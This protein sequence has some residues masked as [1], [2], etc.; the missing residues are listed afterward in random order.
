MKNSKNTFF[1]N[2]IAKYINN[3]STKPEK[4]VVDDFFISLSENLLW[5]EQELGNKDFVKQR[6]K[7][8]IQQKVF[9]SKPRYK[10]YYFIGAVA[11]IVILLSVFNFLETSV[12]ETKIFA[13]SHTIDSLLLNDGSK[14]ILGP[15]SK[16][17]YPEFFAKKFRVIKLKKGNA[18]FNIERD[19]SRPFLVEHKFLD[20]EVLGTSFNINANQKDISVHVITGKVSVKNKN[21]QELI[22]KPTDRGYLRFGTEKLIRKPP[23]KHLAWYTKSIQLKKASL[24]EVAYII[25]N[26]YGYNLQFKNSNLKKTLLTITIAPEDDITNLINQISYITNLKLKINA[27]DIEVN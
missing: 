20:T 21:N 6:L 18:Y 17:E 13:T 26:R 11:C 16:I 4:R 19:S 7:E 24:E 22:L 1:K 15:N 25:K 10:A 8:S 5:K 23:T 14:I 9:R 12:P 2:L 27:N 3:S